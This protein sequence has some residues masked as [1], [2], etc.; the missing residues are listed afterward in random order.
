MDVKHADR[1]CQLQL[2]L[3]QHGGWDT[4]LFA[5][6]NPPIT[7]QLVLY[8]CASTDSTINCVVL[9]SIFTEKEMHIYVDPHSLFKPLLFRMNCIIHPGSP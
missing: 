5:V 7:L 4:D 8:I 2:T 6:E 1:E 9:Q 3:E